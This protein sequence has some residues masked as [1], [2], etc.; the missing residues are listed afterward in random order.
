MTNSTTSKQ[1]YLKALLELSKNEEPIHSA[2]VADAVGVSRASVSKAMGI[3]K[4]SKYI[5]KEKYG[6]IAL[7]QLGRQTANA[8][9]KRNA[10]IKMFLTNVLGVNNDV[11]KADACRMEHT[12]S[13]ETAEKLELFLNRV[14]KIHL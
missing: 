12:L 14:G 9:K 10:L 13:K 5:T 11:A 3:L 4:E 1:D 2:D 8:V 7:T 6:T